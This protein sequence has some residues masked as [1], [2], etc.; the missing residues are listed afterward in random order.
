MSYIVLCGIKFSY[1]ENSSG[2]ICKK[3]RWNTLFA[4][5]FAKFATSAGVE[6]HN[7]YISLQP[8]LGQRDHLN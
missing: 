1:L 7:P 8:L 5:L 4:L 3:F 2:D 6:I